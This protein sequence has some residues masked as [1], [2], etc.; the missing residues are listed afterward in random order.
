L[1]IGVI[2]DSHDN[3]PM[4]RKAVELFDSREDVTVVVHAGDFVAPFALEALLELR[5]PMLGVFGNNDG[6][7][8]GL[9]RL[10]PGLVGSSLTSEIGEKRVC[11][12]HSIDDAPEDDDIDMIIY[13]HDHRA[14][15]EP[16]PPLKVNPGECCGYLTGRP[17]VAVID[18]S[19]MTA[20]IIELT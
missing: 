7:R 12:V 6:E 1:K 16:G 19:E 15:I 4:I 20:E 3:M 10:M 11:V 18:P 14:N 8:A 13:G 2:S 17:T 9:S 5:V